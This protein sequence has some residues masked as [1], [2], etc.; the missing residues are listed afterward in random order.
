MAGVRQFEDLIAWKL[1]EE[2]REF[3]FEFTSR[4]AAARDTDFRSQ[5]RRSSASAP[6][7]LAEGFGRFRPKE[8]ARYAEIARDSLNEAMSQLHRGRKCEYLS[9][10]EYE[11]GIQLAKRAAAAT[12]GLQRYLASCASEPP[13]RWKPKR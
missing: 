5:I 9:Q 4:G 1:S 12:A 8:F 6:D 3:V 7:N 11:K 2:F 13:K 10:L